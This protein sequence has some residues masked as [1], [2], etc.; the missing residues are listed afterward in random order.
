MVFLI[1]WGGLG[2]KGLPL[3]LEH[4]SIDKLD[5]LSYVQL[6]VRRLLVIWVVYE[7]SLN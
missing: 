1:W 5:D 4:G 2:L 3:R 7:S 6:T